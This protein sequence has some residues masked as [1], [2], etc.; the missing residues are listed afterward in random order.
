MSNDGNQ[1]SGL[2]FLSMDLSSGNLRKI[3]L[4]SSVDNGV[5]DWLADLR[6]AL[7]HFFKHNGIRSE[8]N[9]RTLRFTI[10]EGTVS[11]RPL[12]GV[13]TVTGNSESDLYLGCFTS[14]LPVNFYGASY[15]EPIEP[16]Y[17]E[18]ESFI[19]MNPIATVSDSDIMALGRNLMPLGAHLKSLQDKYLPIKT[20]LI[21]SEISIEFTRKEQFETP[22]HFWQ[23]IEVVFKQVYHSYCV[24]TRTSSQSNEEQVMCV[25]GL[26]NYSQV[27]KL[28]FGADNWDS[29]PEYETQSFEDQELDDT[30]EITLKRKLHE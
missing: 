29:I 14:Q 13:L 15:S 21:E 10:S 24:L 18:I 23:L 16:W 2:G 4:P 17:S 7:C 22:A 25:P 11:L 27:I 3:N 12:A 8:F 26:P 30:S 6:P 1:M 28:L 19:S 9:R 5:T 20:T